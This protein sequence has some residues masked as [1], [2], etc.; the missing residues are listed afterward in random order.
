MTI[1]Q[2]KLPVCVKVLVQLSYRLDFPSCPSDVISEIG[3][4]HIEGT[5]LNKKEWYSWNSHGMARPMEA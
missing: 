5:G 2:V 3:F 4:K 1:V